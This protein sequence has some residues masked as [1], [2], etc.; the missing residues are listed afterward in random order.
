[1]FV[2]ILRAGLSDPDGELLDVGLALH[3]PLQPVL[4]GQVA[5][6]A[7]QDLRLA[8]V[9]RHHNTPFSRAVLHQITNNFVFCVTNQLIL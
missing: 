7:G 1:M 9:P 4:A 3:A 5:R 8:R 2:P 6:L